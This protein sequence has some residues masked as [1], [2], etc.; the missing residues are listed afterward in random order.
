MQ[1]IVRVADVWGEV[2]SGLRQLQVVCAVLTSQMSCYRGQAIE[3]YA[4]SSQW[5]GRNVDSDGQLVPQN[6]KGL[7][8]FLCIFILHL[9]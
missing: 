8:S 9:F 4:Y 1:V 7:A 3:M 2:R 5:L 6:R